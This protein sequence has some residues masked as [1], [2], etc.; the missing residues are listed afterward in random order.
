MFFNF[1]SLLPVPS[2][3]SFSLHGK[4]FL[5]LFAQAPAKKTWG[6]DVLGLFCH[7]MKDNQNQG[8]AFSALF[9]IP[10][11]RHRRKPS[12]LFHG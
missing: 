11:S 3:P 9:V 4:A 1:A 12:F 7:T 5:A 10:L 8:K 6:Y 2:Q